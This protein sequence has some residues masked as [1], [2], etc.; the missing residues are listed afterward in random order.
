VFGLPD[1]ERGQK[2]VAAVL[3]LEG[4][5]ADEIRTALGGRLSSY[6]VPREIVSLSAAEVPLLATGKADKRAV[7]E[8]VRQ[9][10]S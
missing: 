5:D 3:G 10:L 6:K 4:G 8:I 9:R 2:V 7:F 1:P